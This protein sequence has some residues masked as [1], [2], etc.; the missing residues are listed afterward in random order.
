MAFTMASRSS[1]GSSGTSSGAGCGSVAPEGSAP[2][3]APFAGVSLLTPLTGRMVSVVPE[4]G[5]AGAPNE[6]LPLCEG[7]CCVTSCAEGSLPVSGEGLSPKDIWP[8]TCGFGLA[9]RWAGAG[10][11]GRTVHVSM[12]LFSKESPITSVGISPPSV[13]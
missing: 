10:L 6:V 5:A 11:V 7:V 4:A 13:L 2:A 8:G 3:A 12:V 1:S 9:G